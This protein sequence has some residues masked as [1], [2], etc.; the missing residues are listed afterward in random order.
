M[1]NARR[2]YNKRFIGADASA[3]AVVAAVIIVV[4][5]LPNTEESI[6]GYSLSTRQ[7]L[8]RTIATIAGSLTGFTITVTTLIL[9]NW[10]HQS[11]TLIAQHPTRSREIRTVLKQSTW[12]M[13]TTTLISLIAIATDVDKEPSRVVMSA[14]VLV[15]TFS[16]VRLCEVIWLV[17]SI[18]AIITTSQNDA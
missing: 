14:I 12:S 11:M 4:I 1:A 18:A 5:W 6:S 3:A 8:Y 17:Q 7:P 16:V 9:G 10:G 13:V 15:T 2:W